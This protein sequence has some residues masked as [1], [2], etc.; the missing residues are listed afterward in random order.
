MRLLLSLAL[1]GFALFQGDAD[2]Q[3]RYLTGLAGRNLPAELERESAAFLERFPGHAR[4]DEARYRL[5]CALFDQKKAA[6]AAELLR[7]LARRRG[8]TFESEVHFRLG[9]CE[10][11]LERPKEAVAALERALELGKDYLVAPT[12]ALLGDALLAANRPDDARARF[13]ALLEQAP[14]GEYAPDA[15]CGMAW[16][17]LKSK[18]YAAA[19]EWAG[20]FLSAQPRHA[21]VAEAEF[22]RGEANLELGRHDAALTAYA[23]ASSGA[24][25]DAALRGAGF[26]L[27]GLGRHADAAKAFGQL[28]ERHPE[29]RF[30]EEARLQRGVALLSAGDA[31]AAVEALSAERVGERGEGAYW[32]AKALAANGDGEAAIAAIEA[33][34]R[35]ERDAALL[36]RFT[37]LRADL[38]MAAGRADEARAAYESSDSDYA[39]QAGAVASLEAGRPK[40]AVRLARKLLER[41]PK[42]PY[43]IEALLAAAEGLF[44]LGE[45]AQAEQ[46]FTSAAETDKDAARRDKTRLRAAWCRYLRKE[47]AD[48]ARMFHELTKTFR[49]GPLADEAAYMTARASEDANDTRTARTAYERYLQAFPRGERRAEALVAS[50]RLAD[51]PEALQRLEQA[52]GSAGDAAVAAEARFELA[53]RLS[54]Q[55][56]FAKAA[57][58][59]RAALAAKPPPA[60]EFSCRYGLAWCEHGA[61]DYAAARR[62]L[63]PLIAAMGQADA[64]LVAGQDADTLDALLELSVWAKARSGDVDAAWA[65]FRGLAARTKSDTRL[66]SAGSVLLR[67]CAQSD[68]P[69]AGEVRARVLDDCARVA[70]SPRISAEIEAER[71]FDAAGEK[72]LDVALGHLD[73]AWRGADDSVVVREA[74]CAVGEACAANGR[75]DVGTKILETL[76]RDESLA[77]ADRAVYLLAF[78]RLS[79]GEAKAAAERLANFAKRFPASPLQAQAAFLE[80][81]A[82]YRAGDFERSLARFEALAQ[83]AAPADLA[84]KILFRLGLSRCRREEWRG[85]EAA[86]ARLEQQFP[87]FE[88]RVEARLWR[89]RARA[90]QGDASAARAL[91]EEVVNADKGMLG[92]QAKLAL[93]DLELA[94]GDP[95]AA[96]SHFLKVAVLFSDEE[97]IAAANYGAG[98]AFEAAGEND[99]AAQSYREVLSKAP[100]S[101]QA[102][103]ARERL[104]RL[105]PR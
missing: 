53:E 52:L 72:R 99:R 87:Q 69:R 40:D 74:A 85:G 65:D 105:D 76:S 46:A 3:L 31:R 44:A 49:E 7:G 38:L 47:P 45:H 100:K 32:R 70:R 61:G 63:D 54:K 12:T 89:G 43:R 86:L 30:V 26:A 41:D 59:Y 92:A 6:P 77:R 22:L 15:M 25:A 10:L 20:R 96:L 98:R 56:E 13:Q 55:G 93:G 57:A 82:W 62:S 84:P 23:R 58:H 66:W 64:P 60:L 36:A 34:A 39:L 21:R 33:A 51:G 16:C 11:E 94:Q 24:Y 18:D 71:A 5:A 91:L 102:A 29:S 4:A 90:A 83:S 101:R 75:A 27:A 35:G 9:Q 103:L 104:T 50:A 19:G 79:A 78:W 28:I 48:A 81:E 88:N 14:K 80:A 67:V 95:R 17:A 2:E 73:R 97:L 8:F 42:S 68:A 37:A 1:A